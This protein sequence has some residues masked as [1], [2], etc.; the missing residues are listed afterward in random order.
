[1]IKYYISCGAQGF[2]SG[3]YPNY[4]MLAQFSVSDTYLK[5]LNI[6]VLADI[7]CS[8]VVCELYTSCHGFIPPAHLH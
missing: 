2:H 6:F 7:T 3:K 1:V 4:S 8:T 5:M